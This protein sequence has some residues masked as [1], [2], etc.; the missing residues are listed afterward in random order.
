[1]PRT[2]GSTLVS[3][4]TAVSLQNSLTDRVKALIHAETVHMKMAAAASVLDQS[5]SDPCCHHDLEVACFELCGWCSTE[6]SLGAFVFERSLDAFVF[7]HAALRLDPYH[8]REM[9]VWPVVSPFDNNLKM[10]A[11]ARQL[12]EKTKRESKG[13]QQDCDLCSERQNTEPT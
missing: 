4:V 10:I 2:L 3:A 5:H 8:H 9:V 12:E 1:M 13:E 7:G 6:R 11:I